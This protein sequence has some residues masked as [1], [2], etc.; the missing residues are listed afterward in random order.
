MSNPNA[1]SLDITVLSGRLG[2]G[3]TTLLTDWLKAYPA[4]DVGLIINEVG[5][6]DIDGAL[7]M[8]QAKDQPITILPSGCL[9]C[10][11]QDDLVSTI[12]TLIEA[13]FERDGTALRAVIIETSGL[14]RPT[15]VVAS[16]LTPELM[17]HGLNVQ[18]VCTFDSEAGPEMLADDAPGRAQL[19]CAQRIIFTK[20]DRVSALEAQHAFDLVKAINPLAELVL[21][22]GRDKLLPLAFSRSRSLTRENFHELLFIKPDP[23]PHSN[24][25]VVC[26]QLD[27]ALDWDRFSAG[28]DDLVAYCSDHLLRT[29][30]LLRIEGASS[31]VLLQSVGY[32]FSRPTIVEGLQLTSSRLVFILENYDE[33][34]FN[35][36]F[37]ITIGACVDAPPGG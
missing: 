33:D 26:R 22:F 21:E 2:S 27:A 4:A 29:K 25:R 32:R 5:E 23:T 36:Q 14:A 3:K 35:A 15:A 1:P 19:A 34:L 17:Q 24:V 13:K 7:V 9:C 8:N 11:M 18:I 10:S 16:L 20:L 6:L 31:A 12:A 28:L 37:G 30:F